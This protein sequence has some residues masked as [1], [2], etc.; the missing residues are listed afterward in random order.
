MLY[1]PKKIFEFKM[2]HIGQFIAI[3]VVCN[4]FLR[5]QQTL[6]SWGKKWLPQKLRFDGNKLFSLYTRNKKRLEITHEWHFFSNYVK[7]VICCRKTVSTAKAAT[8][9]WSVLLWYFVSFLLEIAKN[10]SY[11][12]KSGSFRNKASFDEND[13]FSSIPWNGTNAT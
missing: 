2:S 9:D 6:R 10:N 7:Q 3:L 8:L 5:N 13:I 4:V 11:V 1:P 12:A